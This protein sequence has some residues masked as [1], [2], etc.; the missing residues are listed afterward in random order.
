MRKPM[1]PPT[2]TPLDL[3][4]TAAATR[5]GIRD[6]NAGE[7]VSGPAPTMTPWTPSPWSP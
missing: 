1:T 4:V 2:V 5:R 3:A 7:I 6:H